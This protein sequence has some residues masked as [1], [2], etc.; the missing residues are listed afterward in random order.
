MCSGQGRNSML[1]LAV[2]AVGVAPAGGSPPYA[3]GSDLAVT[4]GSASLKW[5]TSLPGGGQENWWADAALALPASLR[6]SSRLLASECSSCRCN[7][8]I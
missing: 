5:S 2:W 1:L 7:F 6:R 4:V 3:V 8:S